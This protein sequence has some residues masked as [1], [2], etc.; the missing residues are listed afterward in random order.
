MKAVLTNSDGER[1]EIEIP[2]LPDNTM[3]SGYITPV[4]NE[5]ELGSSETIAT[6]ESKITN[7]INENTVPKLNRA[8][9]RAAAK[10]MGKTGRGYMDTI[11]ETAKKLTY[12]NLIQK[13]REMNKENENEEISK[14]N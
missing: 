10:K 9:R 8:Q 6:I 5:E 12:I 1:E 4:Y 11:S 13:L 14:N 7:Q 2:E 3:T